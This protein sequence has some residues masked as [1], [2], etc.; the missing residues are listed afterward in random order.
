MTKE[1]APPANA[2]GFSAIGNVLIAAAG[3][4]AALML[5]EAFVRLTAVDVTVLEPLLY[6]NWADPDVHVPLVDGR[7][8]YG[9][10]AGASHDYE[11]RV[12]SINSLGFRGAERSATKPADVFRIV[13]IGGSTT[14]G[15]SVNDDQTY[16]AVLQRLLDDGS[17]GRFEVWNG[18]VS[19]YTLSQKVAYAEE[20]SKRYAP[21]L[22]IIEEFNTGRR[23]FLER[24]VSGQFGRNA[25]LYRENLPARRVPMPLHDTLLQSGLYRLLNASLDRLWISEDENARKT[26]ES[27]CNE[28]GDDFSRR[29]IS[30]LATRIAPASLIRFDPFFSSN[31]PFAPKVSGT[32][33]SLCDRP[34][35]AEYRE[36]HPP[37]H[38]YEWY[39]R[40]LLRFLKEAGFL[41]APEAALPGKK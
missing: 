4:L 35:G 34:S 1:S 29:Y 14:Y 9:L 31:C 21:D 33:F 22:L 6:Y 20:V 3:V 12:V 16:P 30:E 37:A 2:R 24:G 7:R 39:A 11:G 18:G 23:A 17:K 27:A 28:V 5:A 32:V 15:A 38:V 8:L 25:E 41:G 26:Y 40:E 10:K 19:A 36:V 13:V